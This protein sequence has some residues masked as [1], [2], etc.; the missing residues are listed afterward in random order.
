MA[1][2]SVADMTIDE[3]RA[4]IAQMVEERV[5]RARSWPPKSSDRPLSEIIESMRKNIIRPMPGEPS[6]VEMILEDRK[7]WTAG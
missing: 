1:T 6:A 2:Q 7:R 4:M 5:A 3:L